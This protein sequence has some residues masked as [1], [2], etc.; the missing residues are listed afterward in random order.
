MTSGWLIVLTVILAVN[1]GVFI[2]AAWAGHGR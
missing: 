1:V 2:I